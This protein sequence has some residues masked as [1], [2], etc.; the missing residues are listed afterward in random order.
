MTTKWRKDK[1]PPGWE[2]FW[3]ADGV[4]SSLPGLEVALLAVVELGTKVIWI[5]PYFHLLSLKPGLPLTCSNLPLWLGVCRTQQKPR[6]KENRWLSW[7]FL[8][9]EISHLCLPSP[10]AE[11]LK[12][13]SV[14]VVP[15]A[16]QAKAGPAWRRPFV[17]W[18]PWALWGKR[19]G[20]PP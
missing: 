2:M 9:K 3:P 20:L 7:H 13:N 19:L 8:G 11:K 18:A 4:G 6:A 16:W 17:A 10:M 1:H 5:L 15:S 14:P 12:S